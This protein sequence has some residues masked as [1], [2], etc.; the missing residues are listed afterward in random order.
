[1]LLGAVLWTAGLFAVAGVVMT[2][3]MFHHP[4]APRFFHNIFAH[5]TAWSSIA[6]VCMIAGLFQ[7]RSGLSAVDRL[8]LRLAAVH[9]GSERLVDGTYPA[10]VQPLV[11]DLN[12]LLDH[13]EQAVK[14]AVREPATSRMA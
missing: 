14:R 1:M 11:N 9:Q 5:A 12:V 7:V 6:M 3:I 13:R 10:E 4:A 8:R 2:Q